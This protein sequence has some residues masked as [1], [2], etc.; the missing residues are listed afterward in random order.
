M[1]RV[2]GFLTAVLATFALG[3]TAVSAAYPP[4]TPTLTTTSPTVTPGSPVTLTGSGC[5]A[6][7]VVTFRLGTTV[8]GTAV[9]NAAATAVL[10]VSA[11]KTPGTYTFTSTCPDGL[12][13][14]LSLAVVAFPVPTLPAL[15]PATGT[16]SKGMGLT[17]GV[18][19][20]VGAALVGA[21]TVR[22]RTRV[23]A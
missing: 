19:V 20:L 6:G 13:A 5:A 12:V 23:A 17:A 1:K 8:L 7:A 9:A 21:A 11:P 15:V 10:P 14:S 4:A 3:A 16:D 2:L 22:R 18:L